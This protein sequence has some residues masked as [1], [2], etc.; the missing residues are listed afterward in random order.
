MNDNG[1]MLCRRCGQFFGGHGIEG[2]VC[3]PVE[4]NY[5]CTECGA[6]L[7]RAVAL[8]GTEAWDWHQLIHWKERDHMRVQYLEMC[9]CELR[10]GGFGVRDLVVDIL[11]GTSELLEGGSDD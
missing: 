6:D 10:D 7:T 9:L 4:A 8:L 3:S 11:K 2:H 1:G 5:V